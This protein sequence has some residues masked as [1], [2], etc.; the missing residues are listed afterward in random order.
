[1]IQNYFN[2]IWNI[3]MKIGLLLL[4]KSRKD[5]EDDNRLSE[6]EKKE[7]LSKLNRNNGQWIDKTRKYLGEKMFLIVLNQNK[8]LTNGFLIFQGGRDEL[9]NKKYTRV[10]D[11]R[12]KKFE[13]SEAAIKDNLKLDIRLKSEYEKEFKKIKNDGTNSAWITDSPDNRL[14]DSMFTVPQEVLDTVT[15]WGDLIGFYQG[16][17]DAQDGL[18]A[19]R[20]TLDEE[21][22]TVMAERPNPGRDS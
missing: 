2:L 6:R 17:I 14:S 15:D 13:F 1:M 9:G 20:N 22:K 3:F 8:T 11:P 12:D 10:S 7:Y 18:V 16:I 21:I 19:D 4:K 5:V